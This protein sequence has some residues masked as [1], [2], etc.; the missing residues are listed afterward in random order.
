MSGGLRQDWSPVGVISR[1]C[2]ARPA[3]LGLRR[4]AFRAVEPRQEPF[5]FPLSPCQSLLCSSCQSPSLLLALAS[6]APPSPGR[7][8]M[9]YLPSPL[10]P[11]REEG[12]VCLLSLIPRV[13][14]AQITSL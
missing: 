5:C 2:S 7:A 1:A 3:L 8:R 11:S 9:S 12:R 4:L 14:K 6:W 10:P 13:V